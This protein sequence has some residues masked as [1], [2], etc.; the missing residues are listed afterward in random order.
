MPGTHALVEWFGGGAGRF[1]GI[2]NLSKMAEVGESRQIH[3][4]EM[5]SDFTIE[6]TLLVSN[7]SVVR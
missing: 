5:L 7:S 2:S 6:T 4:S 1:L 3:S